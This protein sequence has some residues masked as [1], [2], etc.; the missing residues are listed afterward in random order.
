MTKWLFE[1]LVSDDGNTNTK[2]IF[3]IDFEF[4]SYLYAYFANLFFSQVAAQMMGAF[5]ARCELKFQ[6]PK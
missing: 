2:V 4:R 1:S 3:Q 6:P 5:V